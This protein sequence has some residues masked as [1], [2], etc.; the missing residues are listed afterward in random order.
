LRVSD[1][2]EEQ[3]LWLAVIL[4]SRPKSLRDIEVS[5]V[6]GKINDM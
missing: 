4:G 5:Y 1:V 2:F 3:R 6:I